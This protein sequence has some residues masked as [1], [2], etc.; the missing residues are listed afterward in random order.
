M[1]S[2]NVT[3]KVW[4]MRVFLKNA[5]FCR[6]S[7]DRIKRSFVENDRLPSFHG[8]M[9]RWVCSAFLS[10]FVALG[11]SRFDSESQPAHLP[12]TRVVGCYISEILQTFYLR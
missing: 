12:L 11:F 10:V 3:R 9:D 7:V 2:Q 1:R 8:A 6:S 5:T 4:K